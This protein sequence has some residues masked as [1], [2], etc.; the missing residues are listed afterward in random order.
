MLGSSGK[1][2][3]VAI[4]Q[5]TLSQKAAAEGLF[6]LADD[7]W[8]AISV[9]LP[10]R[11]RGPRR[12]DDRVVISGILHVLQSGCAWR[13]C[14][15]DYGPYMTIFNR[16]LRWK[17]RGLWQ[18]ILGELVSN[19]R[20]P[21]L[22]V[23]KRLVHESR[24]AP[25]DELVRLHSD[26]RAKAALVQGGV[27]VKLNDARDKIVSTVGLPGA[28]EDPERAL[29]TAEVAAIVRAY[30]TVPRED[31]IGPIVEWH[32]RRTMLTW[33]SEADYATKSQ[34]EPLTAPR[35]DRGFDPRMSALVAFFTRDYIDAKTRLISAL[36]C[37]NFYADGGADGGQAARATLDSLLGCRTNGAS[38][39]GDIE[40]DAQPIGEEHAD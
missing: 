25:G 11:Q 3:R 9:H 7:Q 13:D 36:E 28:F 14:P 40:T 17:Q 16:Y 18:T 23:S 32:M 15:R 10:G 33:S 4:S 2:A 39:L 35:S 22:V 21:K 30:A 29:A 6:F 37:M 27:P 5:D 8:E 24:A 1:A 31:L 12:L 38:T 19:E 26:G 20:L 34:A